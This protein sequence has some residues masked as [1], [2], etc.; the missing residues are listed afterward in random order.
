MRF[1][2]FLP[3]MALGVAVFASSCD[4]EDDDHNHVDILFLEPGNDE[5]VADASDVH[6]HVRFEAEGENHN[7]EVRV[8][9]EGDP[10]DLIVDIDQHD[11]DQ[12]VDIEVDVDLSG[13]PAGTE[14]HVEAVACE[15]HDCAETVEADIHFS[16]P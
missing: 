2:R 10:A 4:K 8:H 6:I 7:V 1:T 13:Y 5:V 11:H 3:L 15:D 16:I 14:F 9:P 12:V